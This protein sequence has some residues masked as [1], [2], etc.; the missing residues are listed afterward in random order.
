MTTATYEAD[1]ALLADGDG[2]LLAL[3]TALGATPAGLVEHPT[4]FDGF[5]AHPAVAAAGLLT[6]ADVAATR[7]VDLSALSLRNLDPVVTASGDRVRFESLS[8]CNGVYA[9][10]DLLADGIDAGEVGYGTTNVDINQPLRLALTGIDRTELLHV[11]VGTDRLR[12]STPAA[13]HEERKVDLP[14]RWV[15]GFA[16]VPVVAARM[17]PRF[18][19][20]GAV[21][22]TFLATVGAGAPGPTI[23]VAS[24]PRGLR[25]VPPSA[26]G[27]VLVAGTAR[28]TAARRVAR[29]ARR[30]TA[31]AEPSGG[32]GWVFDL[33]GAR[34]TL[35]MTPE[36]YRGF[37]GEGGLLHALAGSTVVQDAARIREHLAWEPVIDPA[38]LA[39]TAGFDRTRTDNALAALATSGK[40]GFDLS[41]DAWFQR[42]LP[43]DDEGV[44]RDNPRLVAARELVARAPLTREGD[45][46]RVGE[47]GH[48]HWVGRSGTAWT[49]TCPWW[50]RYRG[51][52][53]PCKHV[54]AVGLVLEPRP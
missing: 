4:F 46:W 54:L 39:T 24:T 48:Q 14:R 17:T 20:T 43:L 31:Y 8:G 41:E 47:P 25:Q 27:A 30:V 37:S 6:V 28:L 26:R 10:L 32:S 49:C 34:L 13:S 2:P 51:D 45:D 9:R 40:V 16:E 12:V 36:P 35:L 52:R 18:S 38:W 19:V 15:R 7:Y 44:T 21:A 23:A 3:A 33:P 11:A 42:E 22:A 50:V 5:V 29:A 53:G 1:S